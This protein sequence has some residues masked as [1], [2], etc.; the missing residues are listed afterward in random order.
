MKRHHLFEFHELPACPGALRQLVTGFLEAVTSL[1]RP[2]SPG[3]DLLVRAMQSTGAEQFVDLCSGNGGPW[4]HLADQIEQ[5][6]GR[7]PAIVLTDKFPNREAALRAELVP[8]LTYDGESM[9][10]RNVPERL[11][12]VRTLFNGFHHFRPAD[13]QAI[14]QDAG[15]KGQPIVIFSKQH[16]QVRCQSEMDLVD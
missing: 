15:A 12:G 1:F 4:F 7:A 10:A 2:Y 5:K 8:G 13:A 16:G 6:T 3:I 14:L 11:R 9:D